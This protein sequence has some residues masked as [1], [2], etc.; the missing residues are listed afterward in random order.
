MFV[1]KVNVFLRLFPSQLHIFHFIYTLPLARLNFPC[2]KVSFGSARFF[3]TPASHEYQMFSFLV[4][5]YLV[6]NPLCLVRKNG[7]I[8]FR[9]TEMG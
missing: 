4:F 9:A 2:L 1:K 8:F 3:I 6:Q 5:V 7:R